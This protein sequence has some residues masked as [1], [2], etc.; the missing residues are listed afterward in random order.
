[1]PALLHRHVVELDDRA[2]SHLRAHLDAAMSVP[3]DYHRGEPVR[4]GQRWRA[5]CAC[6]WEG[7][8]RDDK[9]DADDDALAHDE[10]ENP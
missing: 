2:L 8:L 9:R 7:P 5:R 1:V 10:T 6:G 4:I 3:F